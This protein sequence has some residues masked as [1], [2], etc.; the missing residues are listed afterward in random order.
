MAEAKPNWVKMKAKELEEKI[1]EIFKE[2]KSPAKIGL[3]LRDKH[4]VPKSRLI[5]KRITHILKEKNIEHKKEEDNIKEIVEKLKAH[6]GKNKHDHSA[7]RALTKKL[8]AL[9]GLKN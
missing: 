9:Q 7:Q 8:W 5:S 4:G 6:L 1:L 3:V 2:T